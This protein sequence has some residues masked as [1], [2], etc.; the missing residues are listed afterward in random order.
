MQ[1]I[2]LTLSYEV[3]VPGKGRPDE[4]EVEILS[5]ACIQI[6]ATPIRD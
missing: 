2:A 6:A 1:N 3:R 4:S 5:T